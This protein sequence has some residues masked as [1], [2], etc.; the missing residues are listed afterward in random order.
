LIHEAGDRPEPTHGSLDHRGAR[1]LLLLLGTGLALA[2]LGAVLGVVGS[3]LNETVP[4]VLG[5]GVPVGVV[6]A[7]V[8]NGLAGLLGT[9]GTGSRLG[10]ALP[11]IAW[12]TVVLLFGS[13]RPEGDLIVTGNGYGMAFI[14]L[15]GVAACVGLLPGGRKRAPVG[16][17]PNR[18]R[19]WRTPPPP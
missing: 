16:P 5:V 7:V 3:F 12:F 10:G 1:R 19:F 8:G 14:V 17:G 11:G 13:L 15:G 9:Q 2:L 4:H 6:L 18:D